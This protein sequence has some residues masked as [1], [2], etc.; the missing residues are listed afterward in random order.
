MSF[1]GAGTKIRFGNRSLKVDK[2]KRKNQ[3]H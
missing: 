3:Q 1:K 2:R